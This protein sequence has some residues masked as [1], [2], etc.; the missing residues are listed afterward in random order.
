MGRSD[1]V[2]DYASLGII[3]SKLSAFWA[4]TMTLETYELL[5]YRF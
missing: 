5:R 2:N 1:W 4:K 3:G